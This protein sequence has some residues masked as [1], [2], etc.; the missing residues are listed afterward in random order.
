MTTTLVTIEVPYDKKVLTMKH[1]DKNKRV[2][3]ERVFRVTPGQKFDI[4]FK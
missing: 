1:Y 3:F 4:Q 2:L